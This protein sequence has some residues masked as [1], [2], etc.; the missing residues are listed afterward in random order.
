ME[1]D[2][3]IFAARPLKIEGRRKEENPMTYKVGLWI[4]HRKA[5]IVTVTEEGQVVKLIISA[6][7]KQ[8]RRSSTSRHSGTYESQK[9][10]AD[11]SRQR[12]FT[13]HLNIYYDAVIASIRS[14]ES[15]LIFGPGEAKGELRKR[16]EGVGLAR[17]IVKIETVDKM[18][19]H[20]IAAK[21]KEHF[22]RKHSAA[23]RGRRSTRRA[24]T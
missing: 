19:D 16:L 7:E 1:A 5:H 2:F 14:A 24:L 10:P 20:Q 21:V 12:A 13:G 18:T 11:D 17:R 15:I 9:V 23:G 4:D 3:S 22:V 6:L 8:A